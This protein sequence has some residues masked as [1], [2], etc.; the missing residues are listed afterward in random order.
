MW[1]RG[2]REVHA[3]VDGPVGV[4]SLVSFLIFLSLGL[5]IRLHVGTRF[6]VLRLQYSS[7]LHPQ[8]GT[9]LFLGFLPPF[10]DS[11]VRPTGWPPSSTTT[12]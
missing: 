11:V 3:A 8:G 6:Q 5:A 9:A 1:E 10:S 12:S 4:L 2:G 7:F